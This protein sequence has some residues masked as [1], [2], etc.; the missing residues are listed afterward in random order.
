MSR[1]TL[2]LLTAGILAALAF[3]IM[4]VRH[5]VLGREIQLPVGPGTYKVTLLIRGKSL[6]SAKL[7]MLC[8]LDF[9]QQHIF[10]EELHSAEMIDKPAEGHNHDRRQI[11]WWQKT[12][13]AKVS[14]EAR[15][16]FFC[17]VDTKPATAPMLKLGRQ[18]YEAPHPGECVQPDANIDP[19]DPAIADLA[20]ELTSGHE[21]PLEQVRALYQFVNKQIASE[22]AVGSISGS[23][24]ECLKAGHGDAAAKSR[25]LAAL[26]R[27]RG[28]P[29]RLVQGL[30]LGRQTLHTWNEVWVGDHW[31]PLC[32]FYGYCGRV[33]ATYLIFGFGDTSPVRGHNV[34]DLDFA[35]LVE[36]KL[37]PTAET[38]EGGWLQRA[39]RLISLEAPPPGEEKL[40]EFLLL[41]PVAALIICICRNL[42]GMSCFGTFA[43][44]LIGLAFREWESLPGIL[45]FVSIILIGW[46]LR[47]VLDRFHLLQVPRTSFLLSMVVV[48]LLATIVAA[49][50]EEL[51][52]TRYFS[53]FPM[54]ILT[55]M[56][57]RFW[58]LETEDSTT[59]SFKTL[60][61]TMVM[62]ALISILC[63]R[64]FV[65][66]HLMQYPETLGLVMALQLVLGRYT[67]YR[68]SELF[69]FRDFAEPP[70]LGSA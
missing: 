65:V 57:E 55:G 33:P 51:A 68:L 67:G 15:Y 20:K 52:F 38:S 46:G 13:T 22:P 64:R 7:Q 58:T 14:L 43:P 27:S 6:G 26:C 3:G 66:H 35:C 23:A 61:S 62:A 49:N 41:L 54:V 31:M 9:K 21:R 34:R 12:P 50:I 16:E 10:R 2:S 56:I 28:I 32:A 24:V 69:R 36:H 30:A 5:Q 70:A 37:A 44:A 45:V 4:A 63:S 40:V 18:L 48:V 60:V 59:S 39:F 47:H 29:A 1:T 17:S 11:M 19:H 25:L 42:I 53:L 8:P